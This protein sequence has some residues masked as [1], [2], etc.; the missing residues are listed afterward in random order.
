MPS[1]KELKKFLEESGIDMSSPE[2]WKGW[3]LDVGVKDRND[4]D[5]P[6]EI[7]RQHPTDDIDPEGTS[8]T[9]KDELDKWATENQIDMT[10]P[11]VEE[12]WNGQSLDMRSAAEKMK[13][14][15][16]M[17]VPELNLSEKARN[18]VKSMKAKPEVEE[19]AIS[20]PIIKGIDS[21]FAKFKSGDK[22]LAGILGRGGE[23]KPSAGGD[24]SGFKEKPRSKRRTEGMEDYE[25]DSKYDPTADYAAMDHGAAIA[26]GVKW[27]PSD[28]QMRARQNENKEK[29]RSEAYDKKYRK[30]SDLDKIDATADENESQRAFYGDENRQKHQ[31]DRDRMAQEQ[32]QHNDRMKRDEARMELEHKEAMVRIRSMNEQ[33]AASSQDRKD[34]KS[35]ELK[36]KLATQ[37]D[38]KNPGALQM[39]GTTAKLRKM[40]P[41]D[42]GLIKGGFPGW[43][44]SEAGREVEQQ[45]Q[46]LY[47]QY[48]K[49]IAGTAVSKSEQERVDRALGSIKASHTVDQ[50]YRGLDELEQ[51]TR[52]R[53][54]TLAG[55]VGPDI[56]N[57]FLNDYQESIGFSNP[58]PR[59][60]Q[61][62][63]SPQ[64]SFVKPEEQE[65][66]QAWKRSIGGN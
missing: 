21:V 66:Y 52:D 35:S 61:A 34:R 16:Q 14:S 36:W 58:N 5:S 60:Q 47:N 13:G 20:S 62:S 45:A 41:S 42:V 11:N 37:I 49:S 1:A 59:G 18:R 55:G 8:Y 28:H 26:A 24:E 6:E 44:K 32:G 15:P 3:G 12:G 39:L 38:N 65:E 17:K 7:E 27:D 19:N 43:M 50:Y 30:N 64:K 9:T 53:L 25:A 46:M 56:F 31:L 29:F 57:E 2:G 54:S 40:V 22:K 51:L 33:R 23:S 48:M 4:I 10:N 63:G